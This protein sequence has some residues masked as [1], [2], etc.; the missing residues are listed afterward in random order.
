MAFNLRF[1]LLNSG[2][3]VEQQPTVFSVSQPK[4][5]RANSLSSISQQT[6]LVWNSEKF[7]FFFLNDDSRSDHQHQAFCFTSHTGV[8]EQT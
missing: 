3:Q 7:L 6:A 2:G 8:L 5:G 1:V 4:P